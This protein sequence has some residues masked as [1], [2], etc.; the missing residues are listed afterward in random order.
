MGKWFWEIYFGEFAAKIISTQRGTIFIG[1][2]NLQYITEESLKEWISVVPQHIDL[3]AGNVIDNIAVGEFVPNMERVVE[4][5]N[6]SEYFRSL[7]NCPMDLTLIWD[8]VLRFRE[9]KNSA[10]QLRIYKQPE[11][12]ILDEALLH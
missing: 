3:F 5:V 4:V 8:T 9:V 2:Q 6:R 11:I 1:E 10:S 12:L 7:N